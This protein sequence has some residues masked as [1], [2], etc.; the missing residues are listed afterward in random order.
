[1]TNFAFFGYD[2]P[3]PWTK[4]LNVEWPAF[5]VLLPML[6]GMVAFSRAMFSGGRRTI[7]RYL[8]RRRAELLE[9]AIAAEIDLLL[10]W[11]AGVGGCLWVCWSVVAALSVGVPLVSHRCCRLPE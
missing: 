8:R 2:S 5:I 7:G 1:M 11:S 4:N 3:P 9:P 10:G 6:F